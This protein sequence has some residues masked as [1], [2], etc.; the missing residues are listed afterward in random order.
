M[1]TLTFTLNFWDV[2]KVPTQ[3]QKLFSTAFKYQIKRLEYHHLD[4]FLEN[5]ALGTQCKKHLQ[6]VISSKTKFE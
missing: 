6:R 5:S 1:I 3:F 2:Y 4:S